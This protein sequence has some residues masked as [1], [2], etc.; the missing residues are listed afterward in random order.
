LIPAFA[1][2]R[3]QEI[4]YLIRELEDEK[5]I[6]VLPVA[7]DSPMAAAAT[8]AYSN[9]TE[10]HDEE[11]AS[12]LTQQRHPLRTHSMVTA[13][14]R[15]ESKKL[16]GAT[17]ARV[18]ISASGMMTGGRVLHHA[19]RMVP[20]P[21]ATIVFVGYQA[22]GTIGRRILDGEKEVKILKQW[23]PVRCRVTKIGGFSAHA[24]WKEVLH[25]LEGMQ[26][27]TPRE[28]FLTHGEPEAANAMA[29]HI[30]ERFGWNVRVP[31]YGERF[32]LI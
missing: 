22:A 30:K 18:I 2:G 3:T 4:L 21:D 1:V 7:V 15:E 32:E 6:P 27:G 31:Q 13:T 10:E 24:D 8:E 9:R 11:Y 17:G 23:V 20:D 19:L 5:A 29:E 25:W 16:N 12:I 26:P 14:S 28:T